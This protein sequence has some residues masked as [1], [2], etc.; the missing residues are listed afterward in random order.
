M[1]TCPNCQ[2]QFEGAFCPA[3]GQRVANA[4]ACPS[5]GAKRIGTAS[6][7]SNCGNSFVPSAQSANRAIASN[8]IVAKLLKSSH[9][10]LF[11][12]FSVLA[13]IFLTQPMLDISFWGE[14]FPNAFDYISSNN[15]VELLSSL[16][17]VIAGALSLISATILLITQFTGNQKGGSRIFQTALIYFNYFLVFAASAFSIFFLTIEKGYDFN[18][19]GCPVKLVVLSLIFSII[20]PIVLHLT[21]KTK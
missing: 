12:L 16:P 1:N 4:T 9:L 10:I 8:E 18:L 6:F 21:R 14:P 20:T 5:C 17:I 19:L 13:L 15:D 3:C 11:T 2:T 7:C